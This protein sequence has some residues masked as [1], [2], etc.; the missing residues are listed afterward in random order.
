MSS[1]SI[2]TSLYSCSHHNVGD[3]YAVSSDQPLHQ[4]RAAA[5]DLPHVP[6]R[7]PPPLLFELLGHGGGDLQEGRASHR[8]AAVVSAFVVAVAVVVVAGVRLGLILGGGAAL[9]GRGGGSGLRVGERVIGRTKGFRRLSSRGGRERWMGKRGL[10][11][12]LQHAG[13]NPSSLLRCLVSTPREARRPVQVACR[14]RA[15]PFYTRRFCFDEGGT[16]CRVRA[17]AAPTTV[18]K[19]Q[20]EAGEA[21]HPTNKELQY[22]TQN[23]RRKTTEILD[24]HAPANVL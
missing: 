16:L 17:G 14:G 18:E 9:T 23:S 13:A 12:D 20:G 10:E 4:V 1:T 5:E 8:V 19:R 22:E 6:R 3:A 24:P 21:R 11:T 15:R 2:L 7:P